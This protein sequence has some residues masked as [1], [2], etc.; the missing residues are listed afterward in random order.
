MTLEDSHVT[1]KPPLTAQDVCQVLRGITLE[2]RTVKRACAQSWDEIYAGLFHIA[3]EGWLLTFFND[4]GEL[5]YC[6]EC[7]SPDGRRWSFDS[8]SHDGLDPILL[9]GR[10]EQAKL[11]RLLQQL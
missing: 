3:V 9:L 5:D 6:D 7:I 11:E 1:S 2:R 8:V 4:C 10:L